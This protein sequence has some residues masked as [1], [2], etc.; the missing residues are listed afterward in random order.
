MKLLKIAFLCLLASKFYC[1]GFEDF[2]I[3][4]VSVE[5]ES[6]NLDES[7]NLAIEEGKK[8]A[9]ENCLKETNKEIQNLS[10]SLIDECIDSY[11]IKSEKFIGNIYQAD[12]S[13]T[14]DQNALNNFLNR[15]SNQNSHE[16]YSFRDN[17]K[18]NERQFS[19][20]EKLIV[21]HTDNPK[22]TLRF[23]DAR[24]GSQTFSNLYSISS[25]CVKIRNS[26][27]IVEQL[28]ARGIRFSIE[29]SE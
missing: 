21:I 25:D 1:Y 20:G 27:G 22:N 8:I 2:V 9:L 14:I 6:A 11:T 23:L 15:K 24:F 5:K 29:L 19:I 3:S 28:K 17:G 4:E 7:K 16:A 26:Q 10:A 18:E 12:I 13:Y